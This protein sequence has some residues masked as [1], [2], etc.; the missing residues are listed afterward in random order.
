ML[1]TDLTP[2]LQYHEPNMLAAITM[3]TGGWRCR[4]AGDGKR[5]NLTNF[6]LPFRPPRSLIVK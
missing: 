5:K 1:I 4:E 2:K 3:A 6:P